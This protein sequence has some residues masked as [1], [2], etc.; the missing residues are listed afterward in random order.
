MKLKPTIKKGVKLTPT[1]PQ[2]KSEEKPKT[3]RQKKDNTDGYQP[4]FPPKR[5]LV[6]ETPST[7][8]NGM[9]KQ[10]IEI[11][12]K[13]FDDDEAAPFLWLQMYQESELYT[14]YMKGKCIYLPLEMY[15]DLIENLEEIDEEC[16]KRNIEC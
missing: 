9:V 4:M 7:K 10:Y 6:R 5:F 14:G 3:N 8:G 11:S 2:Q 12:V 1:Q 13:R 15:G 16:E